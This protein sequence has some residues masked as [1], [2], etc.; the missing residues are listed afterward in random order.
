MFDSFQLIFIVSEA[1]GDISR[2]FLVLN[3][4]I[5]TGHGASRVQPHLICE[6]L[7]YL[8]V[9]RGRHRVGG[10]TL[11]LDWTIDWALRSLLNPT[12]HFLGC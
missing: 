12:L 8:L 4:L 3:G 6:F 5:I 1:I 7:L 11:A 10:D 2:V 9:P